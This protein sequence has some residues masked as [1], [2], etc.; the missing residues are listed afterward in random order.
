M[1][2]NLPQSRGKPVPIQPE[3]VVQGGVL[4]STKVVVL[5]QHVDLNTPARHVSNKVMGQQVAEAKKCRIKEQKSMSVHSQVQV[6]SQL[7]VHLMAAL[8]VNK[9]SQVPLLS[10]APT[11]IKVPILLKWLQ[12]YPKVKERDILAKGF[13]QG[14]KLGYRGPRCP[15]ESEC[16]KSASKNV[17]AAW[18]KVYKEISLGRIVGPFSTPPLATLQCSPIGVIPK[19]QPGEWRLITH[20]SFPHGESINDGIPE[21]ICSV[22]YLSFDNAV[23][24][25][26]KHGKGAWLA[27]T[28][29]KSAFR[30][31]PIYPG[32][33]DLLGFKFQGF[34]FI[35]KCLPMGA[36]RS[37]ALFETFSTFLEFQAKKVTKSAAICHYLDD[38]LFISGEGR[39]ACCE[40]LSSF[41]EMCAE[42]GVPLAPEKTEGPNV[43]LTFLGLE[44]DSVQQLVRVPQD[45]MVALFKLLQ[46]VYIVRGII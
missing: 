11:P 30:L 10:R 20:L 2:R 29:I 9:R 25:V 6:H 13:S 36:S 18:N 28:D 38:F 17:S 8:E 33:F 39:T 1:E 41:Q 22:K 24:L 46:Q 34:Y 4:T 3:A 16:L 42:L 7:Q 35:D 40:L 23:D 19:R 15:R 26:V 27:K 5:G 31:L 21:E 43:V 12:H 14:F 44:I 45:K 32:D 37:C